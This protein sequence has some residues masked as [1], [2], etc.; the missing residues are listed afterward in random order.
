MAEVKAVS[1]IEAILNGDKVT[2]V[3]RI[4]AILNGDDVKPVSREEY[5]LKK[6]ASGGESGKFTVMR[7]TTDETFDSS[8]VHMMTGTFW[9]E[10]NKNDIS[11]MFIT[12]DGVEYE[13]TREPQ[14]AG[15]E[16]VYGVGGT[17]DAGVGFIPNWTTTNLPCAVGVTSGQAGCV[18][19]CKEAGTHTVSV[20][21]I[22]VYDLPIQTAPVIGE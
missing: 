6:S 19:Y 3:S 21:I 2:P 1:R 8:G 22:N 10:L 17:Y 18:V 20:K 7:E 16:T 15:S 4:E 14:S 12:F 11:K 9:L 13:V 5:F